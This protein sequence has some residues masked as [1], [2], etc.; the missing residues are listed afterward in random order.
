MAD[1]DDLDWCVGAST[2]SGLT[3]QQVLISTVIL[4]SAE[5]NSRLYCVHSTRRQVLSVGETDDLNLCVGASLDLLLDS[6][7]SNSALYCAHY[8]WFQVFL[9]DL[10]SA[11]IKKDSSNWM[12]HIETTITN[13]AF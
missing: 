2:A 6:E 11:R 1:T 10:D 8:T 9:V 4:H 5:S 12:A 13:L 3:Q 7:N